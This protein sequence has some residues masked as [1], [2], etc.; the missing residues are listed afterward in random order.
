V[1]TYVVGLHHSFYLNDWL[2]LYISWET[3]SL[4]N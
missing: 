1:R 3:F 4:L 2:E